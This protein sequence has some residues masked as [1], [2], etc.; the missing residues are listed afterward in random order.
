MLRRTENLTLQNL[1]SR[2]A[3][4][5]RVAKTYIPTDDDLEYS[6]WVE[7]EGPEREAYLNS[8]WPMYVSTYSKIGLTIS[9]PPGLLK[10][11]SW[12]MYFDRNGTPICFSLFKKTPLG[13]KAGL[14]GS[15]GEGEAKSVIKDWIRTRWKKVPN[16]YAE[17]SHAVEKLSLAGGAPVLCATFAGE[18]TGDP[19]LSYNEDNLHYTRQIGPILAEKIL[20]GRPKGF[21]SYPYERALSECPIPY[22]DAMSR[23]ARIEKTSASEALAEHFS[24][25]YESSL[26]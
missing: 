13:Y 21:K 10:Y 7:I 22:S 19:I 9:T 18:I 14:T 24:C 25:V 12:F 23:V 16:F 2:V 4:L 26:L 3:R 6:G 17:V 15:T 8:V 1:D 11:H 5:E 20:I